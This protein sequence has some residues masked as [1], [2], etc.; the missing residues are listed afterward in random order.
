MGRSGKSEADSCVV[1]AVSVAAGTMS[2]LRKQT[3]RA[4]SLADVRSVDNLNEASVQSLSFKVTPLGIRKS[5]T[6]SN[7]L[8]TVSLYPK[9]QL[10]I[11]KSDTVSIRLLVVLCH[12]N[13]FHC[14][15]TIFSTR[16]KPYEILKYPT[17]T[18]Y[19]SESICT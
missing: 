4:K 14:K 12:C 5:V 8:L 1:N 15:Q 13:R 3:L 2:L 10:G 9:G 7:G 16:T 18:V 17:S 6:V 11:L 19:H